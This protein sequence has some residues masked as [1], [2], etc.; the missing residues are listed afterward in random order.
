MK[1]LEI[2][3]DVIRDIT[4]QIADYP[5]S[6]TLKKRLAYRLDKWQKL[7]DI[8]VYVANNE[9]HPWTSSELGMECTG[10]PL[11]SATGYNQVGDYIFT[12]GAEEQSSSIIWGNLVVER[13]IRGLIWNSN[14]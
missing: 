5:E 12:V 14:E 6:D 9:K 7:V 4:S 13:N 1:S 11:K 10:M 3:E 8:K 2:Y